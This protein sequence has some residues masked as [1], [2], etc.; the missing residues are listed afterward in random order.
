MGTRA[1][2]R[3]EGRG[4]AKFGGASEPW[5][6]SSAAELVLSP[7]RRPLSPSRRR[8]WP[9][10]RAAVPPPSAGDPPAERLSRGG[11]S[12]R[13]GGWP[14]WMGWAHFTGDGIFGRTARFGAPRASWAWPGRVRISFLGAVAECGTRSA[15]S[16]VLSASA[17]RP[18]LRGETS[19]PPP[20]LSRPERQ[21]PRSL[22][23]GS[24]RGAGQLSRELGGVRASTSRA[25][26]AGSA[27]APH[28]PPRA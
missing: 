19:P 5:A 6:V 23:G 14:D 2:S 12:P 27:E 18:R 26:T 7:D 15:G 9:P 16:P 3:Q 13:P 4:W 17:V 8:V 20:V 11:G 10:R 28:P 21:R 24:A 22:R 25:P 1:A